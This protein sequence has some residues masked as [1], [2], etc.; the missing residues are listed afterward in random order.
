M[1][2]PATKADIAG[3]EAAIARLDAAFERQRR[4]LTWVTA[5]MMVGFVGA[6]FAI[7]RLFHH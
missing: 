3:L 7:V 5:A 6:V 2:E 4:E 1:V